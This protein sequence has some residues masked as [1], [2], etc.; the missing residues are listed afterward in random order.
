MKVLRKA[1]ILF[2]LVTSSWYCAIKAI[3]GVSDLLGITRTIKSEPLPA[4]VPQER[5]NDAV[6]EEEES[7]GTN[8]LPGVYSE[9]LETLR[10]ACINNKD[11][12]SQKLWDRSLI[13]NDHFK[14]SYCP[15]EKVATQTW[16]RR[17]NALNP[18][19]QQYHFSKSLDINAIL[20]HIQ[21]KNAPV[22]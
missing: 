17:F 15:L 2:V 8:G 18:K 13:I 14:L 20:K 21:V 7:E 10:K 19:S 3:V 1:C 5:H 11:L 9:R 12:M 22:I 4:I 6:E 16:T